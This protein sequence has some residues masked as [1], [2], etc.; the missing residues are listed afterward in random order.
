MSSKKGKAN[1]NQAKKLYA[2]NDWTFWVFEKVECHSSN[3]DREERKNRL[4]KFRSYLSEYLYP[5][6]DDSSDSQNE[7]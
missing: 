2:G 1:N 6:T 5:S 3:H 4:A 7:D